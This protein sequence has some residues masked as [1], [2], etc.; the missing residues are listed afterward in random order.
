MDISMDLSIYI[1]IHGNP[2]YTK[3]LVILRFCSS[4]EFNFWLPPLFGNGYPSAMVLL[5][6]VV[7]CSHGTNH[8]CIWHCLA[9]ICDAIFDWGL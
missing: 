7:V 9:T 1:H 5:G 3:P 8:C 6:K 2:A 4:F